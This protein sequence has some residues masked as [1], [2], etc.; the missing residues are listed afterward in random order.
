M[1]LKSHNFKCCLIGHFLRN[2]IDI[3]TTTCYYIAVISN[4]SYKSYKIARGDYAGKPNGNA[5]RRA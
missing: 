2:L 1:N 3:S 4:T 5:Q